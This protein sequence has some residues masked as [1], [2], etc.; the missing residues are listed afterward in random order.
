MSKASALLVPALGLLLGASAAN[1]L[2]VPNVVVNYDLSTTTFSALGLA[3]VP[4]SVAGGFTVTYTA[5]D[6]G[7]IVDGPVELSN[8]DITIE[9]LSVAA[10]GLTID[11]LVD[12]SQTNVAGGDLL[13]S[14]ITGGVGQSI[15]AVGAPGTGIFGCTPTTLCGAVGLGG[16]FPIPLE[17]PLSLAIDGVQLTVDSLNS[18]PSNVTGQLALLVGETAVDVLLDAPEISRQFNPIPEPSTLLMLLGGT[19]GLAAYGGRRRS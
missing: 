15:A 13:G 17:G 18:P 19:V 3:V 4:T 5:D 11:A 6:A 12:I 14:V 2:P 8:F 9:D 10:V 7:N 1:A 16:P